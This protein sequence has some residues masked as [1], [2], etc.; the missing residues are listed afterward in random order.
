MRLRGGENS[1]DLI[2]DGG[3]YGDGPMTALLRSA[4]R[5][6]DGEYRRALQDELNRIDAEERQA[7]E[8]Q[9]DEV[10]AARADLANGK[11]VSPPMRMLIET[12]D[13]KE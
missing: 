7:R 11:P 1:L 5:D 8:A 10:D 13:A 6:T 9:R 12:L 3:G 2:G 4:G